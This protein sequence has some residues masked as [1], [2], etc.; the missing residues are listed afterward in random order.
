MIDRWPRRAAWQAAVLA[1]DML[2]LLVPRLCVACERGLQGSERWL[3][4]NCKIALACQARPIT[5]VVDLCEGVSFQVRYSLR[6]TPS[7]SK[8]IAEMKYG[9]KP[10]L[11]RLMAPFAA[12]AA[13]DRIPGDT[14]AV[15]VPIHASKR[16]ERGFNQSRILAEA[17]GA[18]KDIGFGDVL[19]KNRMTVSQTTLEREQRPANVAGCFGVVKSQSSGIRRVLLVDDV[20]TTGSTLRECA[21]ALLAAGVE[22]I[23]ACAVAGSL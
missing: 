15:P 11:A 8:I 4:R 6:Y 7:V 14:L 12:F 10:G 16:R 19:V 22:E 3:C 17:V 20:V 2:R 18:S 1:R 23:S 21:R 9:D 5:R 13:G